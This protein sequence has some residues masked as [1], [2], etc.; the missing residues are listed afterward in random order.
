MSPMEI[1]HIN[2]C[3][4][5]TN[6]GALWKPK[7]QWHMTSLGKGFFEFNFA[8]QKGFIAVWSMGSWQLDPNFLCMSKRSPNSSPKTQKQNNIQCW[9]STYMRTNI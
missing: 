5:K 2:F 3:D 4:F 8:S 1:N 7:G 9:I 6:L